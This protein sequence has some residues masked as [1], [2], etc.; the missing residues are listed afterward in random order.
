MTEFFTNDELTDQSINV[1]GR[2]AN[3]YTNENL[4][5]LDPVKMTSIKRTVLGYVDGSNKIKEEVWKCC[6]KAMNKKM[7]LLKKVKRLTNS[8]WREISQ[9]VT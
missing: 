5:G 9:T 1:L 3:G 7:S 8:I 6:I 4:K 2:S